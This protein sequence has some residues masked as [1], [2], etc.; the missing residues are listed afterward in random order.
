MV[1]EQHFSTREILS[2]STM[3]SMDFI[4]IEVEDCTVRASENKFVDWR[5]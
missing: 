4:L 5:F 2:Q 1:R 3:L